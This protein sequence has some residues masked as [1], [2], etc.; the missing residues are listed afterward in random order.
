M[1]WKYYSLATC[2]CTNS[3]VLTCTCIFWYSNIHLASCKHKNRKF[4][5]MLYTSIF[6]SSLSLTVCSKFWISLC[7]ASLLSVISDTSC[8]WKLI[9]WVRQVLLNIIMYD[10]SFSKNAISLLFCNSCISKCIK[11]VMVRGLPHNSYTCII[12]NPTFLYK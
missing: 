4:E 9:V 2:T 12:Y 11:Y 8:Y 7:N 1:R 10:Y 5:H 6:T 3:L